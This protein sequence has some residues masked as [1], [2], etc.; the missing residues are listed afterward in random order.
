MFAVIKTGGKQY[1]VQEGDVLVIEK[2]GLDEGQKITFDEVLLVDHDQKTLIGTP[3]IENA[4]VKGEVIDNFKDKKVIVFKKKRRKQYKK[5]RGHRQELTRV[6]IEEIVSELRVARKKEPG[7]PKVKKV[8]P[9]EKVKEEAKPKE[10][11]KDKPRKPEKPKVK[12]IEAK[13]KKKAGAAKAAEPKAKTAA[14]KK[15]TT[16]AAPPAKKSKK[17]KE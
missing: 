13:V 5:K 16:K 15:A 6:R 9:R 12:D 3:Y 11:K 1:R 2:L 4:S 10:V 17:M 14:R 7:V 8:P